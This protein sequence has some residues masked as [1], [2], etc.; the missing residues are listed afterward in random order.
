MKPTMY[1]FLH[2]YMHNVYEAMVEKT[3]DI[4]SLN[5]E[6]NCC[7]FR[8][9]CKAASESGCELDCIEF[10]KSQLVDGEDFR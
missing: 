3:Y 5:V 7:P 8:E 2:A 6:C 1:E 4:R 9:A 10:I